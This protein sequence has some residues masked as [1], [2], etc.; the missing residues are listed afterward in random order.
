MKNS[1]IQGSLFRFGCREREREKKK[2]GGR[3]RTGTGMEKEGDRKVM[4]DGEEGVE[5]KRRREHKQEDNVNLESAVKLLALS[6]LIYS[7][8]YIFLS[9]HL[10]SLLKYFPLLT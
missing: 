5:R 1:S 7:P 2:K 6:T 8:V 4:K 10:P 3:R 9:L